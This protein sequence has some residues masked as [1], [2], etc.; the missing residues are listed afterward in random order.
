MWISG[1]EPA[2]AQMPGEQRR[3]RG[4]VDVVVAEDRDLLAARRGVRDA[5][6]PRLPSASRCRD[7]AS[8]CGWSDRESPR[9][10]RS[11]RRARPAPAPA[12]PAT[13]SAA[14]SPAPAPRPAHRAGRATAFRSAECDTPRN[15]VGG[16]TGNADAGSVMMPSADR[17]DRL[18]FN[19][20]CA[21]APTYTRLPPSDT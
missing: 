6:S 14:R 18:G 13:G 10:R 16:S 2:M 20:S 15:A 8:A 21:P 12:S 5:A 19:D 4:A 17:P 9:P 1:I 11:R 7:R 3:R